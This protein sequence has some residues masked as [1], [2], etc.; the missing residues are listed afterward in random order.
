M[1]LESFRGAQIVTVAAAPTKRIAIRAL[2]TAEV[3]APLFQGLQLVDRIIRSD[4]TDNAYLSEMACGCSEESS[5]AAKYI[6]G[7]AER[8]LYGVER[9]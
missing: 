5:G 7:L 3:D 4:D 9:H 8:R 6:V 2:E 1:C